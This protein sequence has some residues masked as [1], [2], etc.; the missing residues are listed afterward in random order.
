MPAKVIAVARVAIG[1]AVG[2]VIY[3]GLFRLFCPSALE[4]LVADFRRRSRR[5]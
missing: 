4:E 5:R 3:L 2:A 1:T